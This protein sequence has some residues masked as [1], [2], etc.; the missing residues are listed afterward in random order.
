MKLICVYTQRIKVFP[1]LFATGQLIHDVFSCIFDIGD[2]PTLL[3]HR[4]FPLRNR[5][6]NC[7]WCDIHFL[8]GYHD[9]K[10][11][12]SWQLLHG[13]QLHSNL[14]LQTKQQQDSSKRLHLYGYVGGRKMRCKN[15]LRVVRHPAKKT[16]MLRIC[17]YCQKNVYGHNMIEVIAGSV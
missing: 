5:S 8:L 2:R 4:S 12:K 9:A 14:R 3:L 11:I 1:S 13:E 10:R 17:G 6:W 7:C 16:K 15:C